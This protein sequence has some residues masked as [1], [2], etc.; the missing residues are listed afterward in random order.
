MLKILKHVDLLGKIIW[1]AVQLR[2]P[3]LFYTLAINNNMALQ[4]LTY[5]KSK[6]E[7]GD[8]PDQNDFHDL[9]DSCFNYSL[10]DTPEYIS[11][12]SSASGNWELT[13]NIVDEKRYDWDNAYTI[14]TQYRNTSSSY[15]TYPALISSYLKL[16]GGTVTNN[17]N[18]QG[19]ILSAG[20]NLYSLFLTPNNGYQTLTYNKDTYALSILNGNTVSLSSIKPSVLIPFTHSSFNLQ[21]N[22]LYVFGQINRPPL[23]AVNFSNCYRS[24]YR[25]NIKE[26]TL[27]NSYDPGTSE[28][29]SF[30]LVNRTQ[31]LTAQLVS[32]IRYTDTLAEEVTNLTNTLKGGAPSGWTA[33]LGVTF[34]G[35][36]ASFSDSSQTLTTAELSNS[37]K[38]QKLSVYAVGNAVGSSSA[39]VRLL[40][41]QNN[42]SYILVASRT[43]NLFSDTLLNWGEI[44]IPGGISSTF[45][46]KLEVTQ[47][48]VISNLNVVGYFPVDTRLEYVSLTNPMSVF[49]GDLLDVR[50][51]TN[52]FVTPPTNVVNLVNA[53]LDITS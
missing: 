7:K 28:A 52:T 27:Q 30:F 2:S 47:P 41:S 12:L 3:P 42:S 49:P 40:Y 38:F 19:S 16:S 22:R 8:L 17:L 21:N 6:F 5:L 44:T 20:V 23:T 50:F 29:I 13:Y 53:K 9:L 24:F 33:T 36:G 34:D 37:T 46:L 32:N 35:Q 1:T 14:S 25:G 4:T 43:A 51:Q 39:G 10:S 31:N 45:T 18:V 48:V 11:F 15:V 26:L